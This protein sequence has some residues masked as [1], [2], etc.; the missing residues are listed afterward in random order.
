MTL[1]EINKSIKDLESLK[2]HHQNQKRIHQHHITQIE[3]TIR[4]FK[5]RKKEK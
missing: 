4:D 2:R 5:R 1:Q 3:K